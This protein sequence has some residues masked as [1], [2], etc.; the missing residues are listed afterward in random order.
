MTWKKIHFHK[1]LKTMKPLE[2]LIIFNDGK[3]TADNPRLI[4][5]MTKHYTRLTITDH[6]NGLTN[7]SNTK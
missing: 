3:K 6:E 7:G 2:I 5:K 4:K 1:N